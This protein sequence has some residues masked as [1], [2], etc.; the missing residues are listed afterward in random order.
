MSGRLVTQNALRALLYREAVRRGATRLPYAPFTVYIDPANACN[1]RCTFCPQS[2]WQGGRRGRM[3]WD[4]FEHVLPQAAELKPDWVFLFCFGEPLLH[5]RLPEMIRAAGEAGMRVRIH[6]N[7]LLM[8]DAMAERLVEADLAECRFSFDTADRALYERMRQG[9]DFDR[10]V[11]GIRALVAARDRLGRRRP[12]VI[13]QELVPYEAGARAAN[14]AAYRDLFVGLDVRLKAKFMHSFAGQGR[15]REFA[16]QQAEG[17]SYCSQLYRR[18]VVNFD[19]KVHAC[20]LDPF[21]HNVVADL[22]AGD[23]LAEAWNSAGM[24]ALRDRTNRGDVAGLAPCEGC[25]MLARSARRTP[26]LTAAAARAAWACL[27]RGCG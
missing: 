9:G 23:T 1:L 17:R 22:A 20:C 13:L 16:G 8:T 18:I 25:E 5:D 12:E 10:A 11:A 21:G 24:Q 6:T 4:T 2:G 7:G 15:E 3:A 14:T 27:G 19:G 26:A